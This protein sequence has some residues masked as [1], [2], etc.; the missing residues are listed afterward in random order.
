MPV[1][2]EDSK[3]I[4]AP[5]RLSSKLRSIHI[6]ALEAVFLRLYCLCIRLSVLFCARCIKKTKINQQL[7]KHLLTS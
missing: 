3:K 1:F 5:A 2:E 7:K 6:A 4:T